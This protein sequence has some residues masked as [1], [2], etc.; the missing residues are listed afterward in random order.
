MCDAEGF[1]A[2]DD[3]RPVWARE[4][5]IRCKGDVVRANGAGAKAGLRFLHGLVKEYFEELRHGGCWV[6]PE[7][8]AQRLAHACEAFVEEARATEADLMSPMDLIG[9]RPL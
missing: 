8:L 9:A 3:A 7:D 1:N 6:S 5:G 2:S 4:A